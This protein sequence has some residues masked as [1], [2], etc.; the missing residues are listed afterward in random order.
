MNNG[1]KY[2]ASLDIGSSKI[3]CILAAKDA[4]EISQIIG[5]GYNEAKG[6]SNGVISDFSLATKSILSAISEAE[7]QADIKINKINISA[8]SKIVTTKLFNKKIKILDDR[9][10]EDNINES[11]NLVMNDPYFEGKQILHAAPISYSIDGANGIKNPIGM[12]GSFLEVDFIISTIGVNHYKNY[13]ECV[14]KC[15]IDID[16]VIFSGLASGIAVLNDNELTL[17]SVVVEI[18]ATN[19]S[20]SIFSKG[21]F[22]FS[23]VI[24]FGGNNIT[25]AIA[26]YY[27]IS[28]SEAEKIKIMHASAIEH[29][30]DNEISFEAPSIN[31]DN[32]EKFVHVSKKDL[33]EIIKPYIESILK[34]IRLVI[35]KSGYENTISK[36]LVLTGGGSQ[37]DGLEILTKNY[38]NFN[39][40]VGFPKEFKISLENTLNPS[41]SV[42]LGIIQSILK[43]KEQEKKQDFNILMA[44]KNK[45]SFFRN[46]ISENFF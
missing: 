36:Q 8:S 40:R 16:Q 11:L 13:I 3:C 2:L 1:S 27:G 10:K 30:A 24:N 18:G 19:T 28:F 31:Y 37:L 23:E 12:F 41:H 6:I 22:L 26:R 39:S 4:H 46:W 5:L 9:I 35:S 17:G 43:V 45:F 33:H 32:N 21:N 29:S 15:N 38:L 44:K 20:L 14:T 34:W 42:A 25:E 7:K